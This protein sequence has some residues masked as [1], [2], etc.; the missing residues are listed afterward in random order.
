MCE[1]QIYKFN[2]P[3][4][5]GQAAITLDSRVKIYTD[6]NIILI[7]CKLN[8]RICIFINLKKFAKHVL[9]KVFQNFS[10]FRYKF[11]KFFQIFSINF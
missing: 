1:T 11:S 3:A 4:T 5:N 9:L 2:V 6:C 8:Y 10:N 7:K